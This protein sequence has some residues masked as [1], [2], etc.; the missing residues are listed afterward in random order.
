MNKL[1]ATLDAKSLHV[2]QMPE[3]GT[4]EIYQALVG[5]STRCPSHTHYVICDKY[6]LHIGTAETAESFAYN[7][8]RPQGWVDNWSDVFD[9][10]G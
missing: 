8:F 3:S 5:S 4:A 10:N 7:L 2:H 1:I 9:P 6:V